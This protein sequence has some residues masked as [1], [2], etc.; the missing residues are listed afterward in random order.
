MSTAFPDYGFPP[1]ADLMTEIRQGPLAQERVELKLPSR[2]RGRYLYCVMVL[3]YGGSG[4]AT[5]S[6][7][8]RVPSAQLI[9]GRR[10]TSKLV[11]HSFASRTFYIGT[12]T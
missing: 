3:L 2:W 8:D 11:L 7:Y 12:V 6:P 9:R 10:T 5:G 4:R 1:G